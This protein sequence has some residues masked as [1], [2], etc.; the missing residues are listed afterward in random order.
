MDTNDLPPDAFGDEQFMRLFVTHEPHIL[1][2]IMVLIPQVADA[3]DVLQET[4]VALWKNIQS[5][6]PRRPF[7][8][9]ALGFARNFIRRHFRNVRRSSQLS[10]KAVEALL[11]DAGPREAQLERRAEA[12]TVCLREMPAPSRAILEGYY[13][14]ELSVEELS[15]KHA[16]SAEAIYKIIQRLRHALR[17]CIGKRV[18]ESPTPL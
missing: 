9:W 8:N 7:V 3:R 10:E 4:S 17:A 5:Y 12:L 14:H 13:F 11:T 2:A 15:R 1:R 18:D 6:D 16:K